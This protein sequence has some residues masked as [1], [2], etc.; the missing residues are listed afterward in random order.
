MNGIL[1]ESA[2]SASEANGDADVENAEENHG[3][4]KKDEGGKGEHWPSFS[5]V[6]HGTKRRFSYGLTDEMRA[7]LFRVRHMIDSHVKGLEV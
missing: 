7:G 3:D 2:R 6:Q 4:D 5:F 1:L